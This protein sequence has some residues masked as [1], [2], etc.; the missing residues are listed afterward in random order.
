MVAVN[1][2]RF[3]ENRCPDPNQFQSEL[4]RICSNLPEFAH[5]LGLNL[6]LGVLSRRLATELVHAPL[7]VLT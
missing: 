1:L 4:V 7:G 2:P 6:P 5:G 3:L